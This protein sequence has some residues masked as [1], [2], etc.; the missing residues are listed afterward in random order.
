M[1]TM[2]SEQI[3]LCIG[4]GNTLLSLFYLLFQWMILP[5]YW[6]SRGKKQ[7]TDRTKAWITF[8]VMLL[9][10]VV[11]PLF[12]GI[13]YVTNRLFF[14]KTVD[15]DDVIFSKMKV[16][17]MHRA[18]EDVERNI[19][20]LEEALAVSDTSSL[21]TLMLNILKGDISDSLHSISEALN[22]DDSETAHYAASVLRDELNDFR[23]QVQKRY[24]EVQQGENV[25]KQGTELLGYMND[26]LS[27]N[28][29]SDMEQT[30]YVHMMEEIA[31]MVL[32][33][34]AVAMQSQYYEWIT[35]RLL[36]VKEYETC[37]KWCKRA[38]LQYPE[39][40]SSYTCAM[41]LY[42]AMHDREKFFQ[43]MDRLKASSVTIDRETLEMIRT[44][45]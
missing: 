36:D 29:F 34:D 41:K 28:I 23:F 37:E 38:I 43:I 44:F 19:V 9:A 8:V 12:F 18:N 39:E 15:L 3:V 7:C 30:S 11:G 24:E 13:G 21:R 4:I 33:K 35:L 17:S 2:H 26:F 31:T 20:P 16:K 40:L 25:V 32:E 22:S 27:Q 14:R 5:A 10:P 42:F 1:M 45:S 6:R